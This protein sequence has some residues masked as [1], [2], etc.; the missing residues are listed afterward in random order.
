M[1]IREDLLELGI[2]IEEIDIDAPV[3]RYLPDFQ[4]EN[5]SGK[6]I[7]LRQLMSHR[8]GLIREPPVG[9]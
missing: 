7:T 9:S 3:T 1:D 5:P 4:P 2:R 6:A 8:S